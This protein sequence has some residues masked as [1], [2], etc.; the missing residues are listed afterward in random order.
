MVGTF[1]TIEPLLQQLDAAQQ[2]I[3]EGIRLQKVAKNY[4]LYGQRQLNG[5]TTSPGQKL[6]EILKKTWSHWTSQ[7]E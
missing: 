5:N 6:F 1:D 4:R 2:L 3:A 7:V